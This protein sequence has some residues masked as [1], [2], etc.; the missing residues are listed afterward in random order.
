M[1]PCLFSSQVPLT[2]LSDGSLKF[3]EVHQKFLQPRSQGLSRGE[4]DPENEVEISQARMAA[5][6]RT[7]GLK[8]FDNVAFKPLIFPRREEC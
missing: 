3:V 6:H 4:R 8:P 2:F 1:A 7:G 5:R